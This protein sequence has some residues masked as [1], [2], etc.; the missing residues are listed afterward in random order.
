MD[1]G[2]RGGRGQ[3]ERRGTD[4]NSLAMAFDFFECIC[5]SFKI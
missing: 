1:R 2:K 4:G 3:K 5:L